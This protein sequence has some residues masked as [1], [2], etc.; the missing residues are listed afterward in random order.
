[1]L[2]KSNF[3][4]WFQGD[5]KTIFLITTF[6]ALKFAD[7][8]VLV[9]NSPN[10]CYNLWKKGGRTRVLSKSDFGKY[11]QIERLVIL[12]VVKMIGCPDTVFA[13]KINARRRGN[14]LF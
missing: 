14:A 12:W 11:I 1:M 6:K 9:F 7:N 3:Y 5:L 8:T 4:E 10:R 2:E 13:R